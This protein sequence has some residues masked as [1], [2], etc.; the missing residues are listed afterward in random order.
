MKTLTSFFLTAL[1]SVSSVFAADDAFVT[2]W[3]LPIQGWFPNAA[4]PAEGIDAY[5]RATASAAVITSFNAQTADFDATWATVAGAGYLIGKPGSRLGLAASEKGAADFTGSYKIFYDNANLYVLVQWTDD[6]VTGTE[7]AEICVA[8]YFKLDAVDRTG[9]ATAWYARYSQFGANKLA[10]KKTGFAAAM[11]VNFDAAGAGTLDWG[12]T[13][14]TLT[15][16]LFVDDKTAASSKTVKWIISIGYDALEGVHRPEFNTTK[17]AALE[18]GISFDLKIN[19]EDGDD[20]LTADAKPEKKPAEY[21]WNATNNDAWQSTIFAGFVKMATTS[22]NV[23]KM[24]NFATITANSIELNAPANVVVFN[25]VGK[26]V[27]SE[28]NTSIVNI[29]KLNKGVYIVRANN[30]TQ[31]F[32]R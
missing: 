19:D 9:L 28:D 5:P 13:T 2:N 23:V 8:P 18:K 21:W 14:P 4:A 1:L 15:A 32:V 31:K 10:F 26:Q 7:S 11:M 17:W 3:Q 30:K 16:N 24:E 12:G 29:S 20:A 22:N 25:A 6:D 27:I